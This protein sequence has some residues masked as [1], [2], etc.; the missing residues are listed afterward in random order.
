MKHERIYF[1][2]Y[3]QKCRHCSRL[4]RSHIAAEWHQKPVKW[5]RTQCYAFLHVRNEIYSFMLYFMLNRT[6]LVFIIILAV[7]WI[8]YSR[9]DILYSQTRIFSHINKINININIRENMVFLRIM[10][11]TYVILMSN[12]LI[13]SSSLLSLLSSLLFYSLF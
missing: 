6:C 3:M 10:F 11:T 2:S 12:Y 9:W 4:I 13:Y 7:D 5:D 1:I 8:W